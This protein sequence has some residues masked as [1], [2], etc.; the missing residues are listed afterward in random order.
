MLTWV[1]WAVPSSSCVPGQARAWS[2][3]FQRAPAAAAGSSRFQQGSPVLCRNLLLGGTLNSG[4]AQTRITHSRVSRRCLWV[5]YFWFKTALLTEFALKVVICISLHTLMA[6]SVF[7]ILL[8]W[9][10]AIIVPSIYVWH[11]WLLLLL[12]FRILRAISWIIT[13]NSCF[14]HKVNPPSFPRCNLMAV[15][16]TACSPL[17][18]SWSEHLF[19]V[20]KLRQIM[21]LSSTLG[22]NLFPECTTL[23]NWRVNNVRNA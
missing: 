19:N 20:G 5:H 22:W 4:Q 9:S 16:S 13:L 18:D 15:S 10:H 14:K 11:I 8:A 1:R 7:S 21:T 17:L 6:T 12:E 23:K 3:F 2:G